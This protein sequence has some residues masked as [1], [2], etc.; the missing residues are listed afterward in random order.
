MSDNFKKRIFT[1]FVLFILLFLMIQNNYLLGYFLMIVGII[2][3]LEFSQMTSKIYK[4]KK[5]EFIFLNLF[6]LLYVFSICAFFLLFAFYVHLKIISFIILITCI[7]SDIGGYAVGKIVKGR[8]LTKISP[9][10]TVS[11]ALGSL[12][13]SSVSIT[14]MFFYITEKFDPLI[15]VVGLV[16]SIGCQVG[17]LLI[18]SLKRKSNMK[19][20]GN[21][22]PG[23]GGVLDRI[24][25]IILGMPIGFIALTIFY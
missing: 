4:N 2:S 12:I 9:N 21:L 10:K 25:G 5:I 13:F 19:D 24:D 7:A 23:H 1:S 17:D 16:I 15:S 6:F 3:I 22:L 18:S 14:I 11:G 8:K 20:T